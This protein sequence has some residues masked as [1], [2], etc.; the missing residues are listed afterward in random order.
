L[1][2]VREA[3]RRH[4]LDRIAP[5]QS[6]TANNVTLN[7]LSPFAALNGNI[8][9]WLRYNAGWRHDQIGFVNTD[10]LTPANSFKRWTGIDSPKATLSIF[11]SAALPLPAVSLSFGQAFFTNDPRIGTGT[12]QGSLVSRAHA[13][14][15]VVFKTF[16]NTDFRVT[17]ARVTQQASFARIDADTGL[18]YNEGGRNRYITLSGRH[19]FERLSCRPR[20]RKPMPATSPPAYPSRKL[21]A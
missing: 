5:F 8:F 15:S 17:L 9:S 14:Q 4:D 12:E 20:F 13:W 21:L 6:L 7:F 16:L 19:A 11:P 18:Q 10:L 1:N 3:P 2:H